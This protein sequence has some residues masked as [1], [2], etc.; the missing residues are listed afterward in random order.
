MT[1]LYKKIGV[2][3]SG[4]GG[5]TVLGA[6]KRLLPCC[7]YYYLADSKNLPYGSKTKKQI[8]EFSIKNTLFFNS[9]D[10]DCI[11]VACNTSASS[12]IDLIR[13]NSKKPV[14]SIIEAA[15]F[16]FCN[17]LRKD[18]KI[19]LIATPRTIEDG[20]YEEKLREIAGLSADIRAI[21]TPEL[22]NL[23]ENHY[24]NKEF[25]FNEVSRIFDRFEKYKNHTLIFGCTHYPFLEYVIRKIW[26]GRILNPSE[27][28]PDFMSVENDK[29]DIFECKGRVIMY[30]T[31]DT[32]D[33][34]NKLASLSIDYV[35][36]IKSVELDRC[37]EG[38][39]VNV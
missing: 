18:E 33:M 17:V 2:F 23:I 22:V 5:L 21:A 11:L 6:M 29:T 26:R 30:T 31:G 39:M 15:E 16:G 3:D 19:L 20:I 1:W 14:F 34:K 7:E 24:D 4:I 32:S 9:L 38:S 27:F 37:G 36:E 10:V 35:Q 12:A 28:F 8:R 13:S 25:I